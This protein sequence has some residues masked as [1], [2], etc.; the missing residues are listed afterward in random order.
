MLL[1]FSDLEGRRRRPI[2]HARI[3]TETGYLPQEAGWKHP[4]QKL[5]IPNS[6]LYEGRHAIFIKLL[7]DQIF[8]SA[9]PLVEVTLTTIWSHPCPTLLPSTD[10]NSPHRVVRCRLC[11][12]RREMPSPCPRLLLSDVVTQNRA[13]GDRCRRGRTCAS[14]GSSWSCLVL[15]SSDRVSPKFRSGNLTMKQDTPSLLRPRPRPR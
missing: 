3:D 6:C 5:G 7:H 11:L 12:S 15:P 13:G 14:G 8:D 4:F 10:L 2:I 1:R 9:T